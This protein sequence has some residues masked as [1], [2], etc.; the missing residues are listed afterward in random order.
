MLQADGPED[1]PVATAGRNGAVVRQEV[2]LSTF[3][4]Q[5]GPPEQAHHPVNIAQQA[6]GLQAA[7]QHTCTAQTLHASKARQHEHCRGQAL[8][9]FAGT[10]VEP[11]CEPMLARARLEYRCEYAAGRLHLCLRAKLHFACSPA[12]GW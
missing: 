11:A 1:A 6:Q 4:V 12:P 5:P 10:G 9:S 8:Q 3:R 2:G 7:A